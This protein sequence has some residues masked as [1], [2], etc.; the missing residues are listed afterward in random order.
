MGKRRLFITLMSIILGLLVVGG[1]GTYLVLNTQ[2]SDGSSDKNEPTSLGSGDISKLINVKE[3]ATYFSYT[4]NNSASYEFHLE[5]SLLIGFTMD[6]EELFVQK[7]TAKLR[8][9]TSKLTP[10][11]E[12]NGHGYYTFLYRLEANKEYLLTTQATVNAQALIKITEQHATPPDGEGETSQTLTTGYSKIYVKKTDTIFT[13]QTDEVSGTYRFCLVGENKTNEYQLSLFE[14]STSTMS[15]EFDVLDPAQYQIRRD[16]LLSKSHKYSLKI[17]GLNQAENVEL[18]YILIQYINATDSK[19][20][21]DT[22]NEA[23][24]LISNDENIVSVSSQERYFKIH[25][26]E[27]GV[28]ELYYGGVPDHTVTLTAYEAN[29]TTVAARDTNA[30]GQ[31]K[32]CYVRVATND[33]DLYISLKGDWPTGTYK[34][35]SVSL[36]NKMLSGSPNSGW[37]VELNCEQTYDV[38]VNCNTSYFSFGFHDPYE[39]E[40]S[41]KGDTT[42]SVEIDVVTVDDEQMVVHHEIIENTK[43]KTFKIQFPTSGSHAIGIRINDSSGSYHLIKIAASEQQFM[44]MGGSSFHDSYM[45]GYDINHELYIKK[46]YSYFML[47]KVYGYISLRFS[48]LEDDTVTLRYM[49]KP[50][51]T[52]WHVETNESSTNKTVEIPTLYPDSQLYFTFN[53][54][55]SDI[56]YKRIDVRI[57]KVEETKHI[58]THS[59]ELTYDYDLGNSYDLLI[60]GQERYFCFSNGLYSLDRFIDITTSGLAGYNLNVKYYNSKNAAPIA[61]TYTNGKQET[62]RVYL[63]DDEPSEV[64]HY[65]YIGISHSGSIID[66]QH[67]KLTVEADLLDAGKS[68]RTSLDFYSFD[69]EGT[70]FRVGS[71]EKYVK[72]SSAPYSEPV[73]RIK[74]H[75]LEINATVNF[76]DSETGSVISSHTIK[77]GQTKYL[78]FDISLHGK[79]YLGIR[80]VGHETETSQLF[81]QS[82]EAFTK[83]EEYRN[84]DGISG[85]HGRTALRSHFLYHTLYEMHNHPG[86]YTLKFSGVG[87]DGVSVVVRL[88][89]DGTTSEYIESINSSSS[90]KSFS[91]TLPADYDKAYIALRHTGDSNRTYGISAFFTDSGKV[92]GASR[93]SATQIY[94]DDLFQYHGVNPLIVGSSEMFY[95]VGLAARGYYL[96]EFDGL[97]SSSV[98]CNYYT[99]S[100]SKAQSTF[101]VGYE[102]QRFYVYKPDSSEG[103]LGFR[104]G[105]ASTFYNF[106]HVRFAYL[107]ADGIEGADGS[108]YQTRPPLGVGEFQ[109]VF[110]T[111]LTYFA[112]E[113][114]TTAKFTFETSG[115]YDTRATLYSPLDEV[116]I[117]SDSGGEG[118]NFKFEYSLEKYHGY[119]LGLRLNSGSG[120]HVVTL[121]IS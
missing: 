70:M 29:L 62:L 42:Y 103:F 79:G 107:G 1:I 9:N 22:I 4:S 78:F 95:S 47:P 12:Y 55:S 89:L 19:Y 113:A 58:G 71:V 77:A 50:Y 102:T 75:A 73:V 27:E 90:F 100:S 41:Y 49:V 86:D 54:E 91:F 26:V 51:D 25:I 16:Y 80:H 66:F 39:Y 82:L 101:T 5:G 30:T 32:F 106:I 112:F 2:S 81:L 57:T 67:V 31:S 40:V 98:T 69:G 104:H 63:Y 116:L 28:Y 118:N 61:T 68:N 84:P 87:E 10:T 110:T 99:N 92:G 20:G 96:L 88:Y 60:N 120:T 43:Q 24:S 44:M 76:Y 108:V 46:D 14:S 33:G 8:Q 13:F 111:D 3:E 45:L 56:L 17:K 65:F 52:E 64:G 83:G 34:P 105:G 23:T 48:G 11:Y 94:V 53:F 37:P 35:V 121:T 72:F 85:V 15:Y 6:V 119:S 7:T 59:R 97:I 36:G 21:S 115:E 74:F 38:V 114:P 18:A 117:V 109:V 93:L